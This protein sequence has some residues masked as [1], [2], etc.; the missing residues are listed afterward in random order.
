MQAGGALSLSGTNTEQHH[1]TYTDHRQR[2]DHHYVVQKKNQIYIYIYIEKSG[3]QRSNYRPNVE[4]MLN[5]ASLKMALENICLATEA[6]TN[7]PR[8][9]WIT[10]KKV[11]PHS[12]LLSVSSIVRR[13]PVHGTVKC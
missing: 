6:P 5:T 4:G 12:T 3:G 7:M 11:P 8:R 9:D 1:L 2:Q 10:A 13:P